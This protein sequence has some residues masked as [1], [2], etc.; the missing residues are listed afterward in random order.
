MMEHTAPDVGGHFIF[1]HM[2]LGEA[3]AEHKATG[4]K[5]GTCIGRAF[6]RIISTEELGDI[7]NQRKAKLRNK[8]KVRQRAPTTGIAPSPAP[9]DEEPAIRTVSLDEPG[10]EPQISAHRMDNDQNIIIGQFLAS[11]PYEQQE[12]VGL[13]LIDGVSIRDAAARLGMARSTAD[14]QLQ[15]LKAQLRD[16]LVDGEIN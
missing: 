3:F 1:R 8:A 2:V 5:I 4:I 13:C 15:R 12:L 10:F 9:P 6:N 7:K 11:L 16:L 14:R